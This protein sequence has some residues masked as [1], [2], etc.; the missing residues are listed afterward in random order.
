MSRSASRKERLAA[1]Q[2]RDAEN[3]SGGFSVLDTKDYPDIPWLKLEPETDYAIDLMPYQVSSKNHPDYDTFKE[4]DWWEDYKLDVFV[5]RGVGPKYK[6][7]T[8]PQKNFGKP[9]PIC[10][11]HDRIKEEEKLEWNDDK[12][13]DLRPS[14]RS[15]F[16]IYDLEDHGK[17][18]FFE[19]SYGWFTKNLLAQAKRKSKKRDILL[20]DFS[21]DGVTIEFTPDPST[22]KDTQP[23]EVKS[24]DFVKRDEG[25]TEDDFENAPRLDTMLKTFTYEEI[26]DA[27]YGVSEDE[28]EGEDVKEEEEVKERPSRRKKEESDEKESR[29]SRRSK[30]V[31]E[32]E[33][34]DE[35]KEEEKSSRRSNR[36][37]EK[38]SDEIECPAG[39]EFGKD[40]DS[41]NCLGDEECEH[42]FACDEAYGENN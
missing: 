36:K 20:G 3:K 37:R 21:E 16:N 32:A 22:F 28:S 7:F 5:H 24:F 27:F 34:E 2:K 13:Q 18:K 11:E 4:D 12:L 38:K 33:E 26:E 19:Y 23:G 41:R 25:Y 42:Y 8:C 35:D 40:I 10:E 30:R 9:C 14:K 1:K 17:Q 29:S 31:R 6:S 39:L 15:F